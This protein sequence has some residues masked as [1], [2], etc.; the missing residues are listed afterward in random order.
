MD[1][2]SVSEYCQVQL[3]S[4]GLREFFFP[5][6]NAASGLGWS[7]AALSRR[8]TPCLSVWAGIARLGQEYGK[9]ANTVLEF[10]KI[11]L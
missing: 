1:T 4:I 5:F 11:I 7:L 10:P 2:A 9:T 8:G 6:E 3:D